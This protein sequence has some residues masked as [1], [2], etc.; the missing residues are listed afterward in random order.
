MVTIFIS[1]KIINIFLSSNETTKKNNNFIFLKEN[2]QKN[3]SKIKKIL[4]I[5]STGCD[6]IINYKK[7]SEKGGFVKRPGA[8]GISQALASSNLGAEVAFLGVIGDDIC[9][10]KNIDDLEKN[11]IKH[12]IKVIPDMNTQISTN[13][14]DNNNNQ[15]IITIMSWANNFFDE[16]LVNKNIKLL[17]EYDIIVLQM[18]IPVKIVEYVIDIAYNS[19]KTI[20]L[21]LSPVKPISKDILKKCNYIIIDKN[22][23]STL[24]GMNIDNDNQI[25]LASKKFYEIGIQNLIVILGEKGTFLYN[26]ETS[27]FFKI[28]QDYLSDIKTKGIK[29]EN[30]C[31]IG[32]FANYLAKDYSLIGTIINTNFVFRYYAVMKNDF[33]TQSDID[34]FVDR[35]SFYT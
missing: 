2:T 3:K 4:F 32:A 29:R 1:I 16:E 35:I 26:K 30:D 24:T 8:K 25:E 13:I 17:N 5:G 33:P 28:V 9:G 34:Y 6:W 19:N 14:F 12:Y 7:I 23:L 31:Y 27:R 21:N 22:E 18:E 10:E 15:S 20:I 11:N